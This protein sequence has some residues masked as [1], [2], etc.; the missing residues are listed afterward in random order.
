M[1]DIAAAA[2]APAMIAAQDTPDWDD[3]AG[4]GSPNIG[5]VP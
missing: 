3:K 1:M 4:D 5:G 2:T